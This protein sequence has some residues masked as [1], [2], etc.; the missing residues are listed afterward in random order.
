MSNV[1]LLQGNLSCLLSNEMS[2]QL[3]SKFSS[4]LILITPLQTHNTLLSQV[5]FLSC[6]A[7]AKALENEHTPQ[8]CS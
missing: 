5:R 2:K 6:H 1:C 4:A 7:R 3:L 8:L